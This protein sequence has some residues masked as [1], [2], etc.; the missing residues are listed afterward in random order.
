[1]IDIRTREELDN[2][3]PN[4]MKCLQCRCPPKK[5]IPDT[6]LENH[7]QEGCG[8]RRLGEDTREGL[9]AMSG[10]IRIVV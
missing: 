8:R 1:M 9:F 10:L 6:N 7:N 3:V 2:T 4:D 5:W